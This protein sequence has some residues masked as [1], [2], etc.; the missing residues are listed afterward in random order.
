VDS[1]RGAEQIAEDADAVGIREA[2]SECHL[3]C[4]PFPFFAFP[5]TH[6]DII[7]CPPVIG[8]D[9]HRLLT[10][11]LLVR[12]GSFHT[13]SFADPWDFV[14]YVHKPKLGL[15]LTRPTAPSWMLP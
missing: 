9:P 8:K 14:D 13:M 7:A 1:V 3:G 6:N 15:D 11:P 12:D 10:R 5:L 4:K 2:G